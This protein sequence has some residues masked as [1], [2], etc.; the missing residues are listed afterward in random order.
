LLYKILFI[1]TISFS[2][3]TDLESFAAFISGLGPGF[4]GAPAPDKSSNITLTTN[5]IW[6]YYMSVPF[7]NTEVTITST[8]DST[9]TPKTW[10]SGVSMV[11]KLFGDADDKK[12]TFST[13]NNVD[14]FNNASNPDQPYD[15]CGSTISKDQVAIPDT[16]VVV[17]GLDTTA[18]LTSVS[19]VTFKDVM[20]AFNFASED[21][22]STLW[23]M[24]T[25]LEKDSGAS[26]NLTLLAVDS[27]TDVT[28][29]EVYR[30][31]IWC[32][33]DVCI[34]ASLFKQSCR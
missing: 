20:S 10:I 18:S 15:A 9:K 17:C 34:H 16:G 28:R 5:D 11:C 24:I 21:D 32:F 14:Q 26:L 27:E 8:T 30:N 19:P 29:K 4:I 6:G 25:F 31:A 1:I 13:A 7:M 2:P 3:H 22:S 33:A 12:L 23:K